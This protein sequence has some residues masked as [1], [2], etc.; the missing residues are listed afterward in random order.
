M[1]QLVKDDVIDCFFEIQNGE[2]VEVNTLNKAEKRPSTD[3]KRF[4][5]DCKIKAYTMEQGAQAYDLYPVYDK[6]IINTNKN[7]I[8]VKKQ[9]VQHLIQLV[10]YLTVNIM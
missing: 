2:I 9:E 3:Q 4:M 6:F 1:E 5:D 8:Q 10:M 7:L